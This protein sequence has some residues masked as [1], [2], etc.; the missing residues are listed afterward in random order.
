[1]VSPARKREAVR[2]AMRRLGFGRLS[3]ASVKSAWQPFWNA[4]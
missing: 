3:S 2:Y 1:M 4:R